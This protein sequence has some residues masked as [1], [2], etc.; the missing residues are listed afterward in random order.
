[1][2]QTHP[3]LRKLARL[4]LR[5]HLRALRRRLSTASGIVFGLLGL[6]FV[7]LWIASLAYGNSLAVGRVS[8]ADGVAVARGGLGLLCLMT[9][10]GS[11]SYRGLYLPRDEV[12]RLLSAPV[13]RSDLIRYRLLVN[14]A[15]SIL[16]ASI[17][18]LVA[19]RRMPSRFAFAGT[20]VAMLLLPVLGQ[21]TAILF[22]GAETRVGAW[23]KRVPAGLLRAA[24]GVIAGV[25]VG[26]FLW[27]GTTGGGP[28]A[29]EE[30]RVYT[31][32]PFG[33]FSKSLTIPAP[34]DSLAFPRVEVV[35]FPPQRGSQRDGGRPLPAPDGGGTSAVGL[36]EF[37]RGDSAR[38]IHWRSS[39]RHNELFVLEIDTERDA[40]YEVRLRTRDAAPGERFEERVSWAASE[41]CALIDAD[42]RVALAT[43][44]Q[45]F[46]A[47]SGAR[48][49]AA[50]LTILARVEPVPAL[51]GGRT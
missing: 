25:T 27:I 19:S 17:M 14:A 39:L 51:A 4:K 20:L 1:V 3:G 29:F 45:R 44:P 37:G 22:G 8:P 24:A 31:R 49:R 36:R 47:D 33:L 23:L 13:S 43:D 30:F 41:V 32:F 34:A 12:E 18:A 11:L 10:I 28:F 5:G 38:R 9:V 6:L 7:G 16:F 35:A 2:F 46:A 26:G 40:E 15:R 50:L 48:H 21:A 42:H